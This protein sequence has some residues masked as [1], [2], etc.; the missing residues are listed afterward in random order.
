MQIDWLTTGAQII[1]FLVLLWLLKRFLYQPVIR[2][3]DRREEKIAHR[4]REAEH[5]EQTATAQAQAFQDKL[6]GWEVE[7]AERLSLIRRLRPAGKAVLKSSVSRS[8]K[9][10]ATGNAK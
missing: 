2:A 10:V 8:K 9:R 6:Q 5:R 7:R 4:I 3:M 1:N